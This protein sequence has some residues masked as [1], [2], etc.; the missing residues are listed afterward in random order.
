M[1]EKT[2]TPKSTPTDPKKNK[3]QE[4]SDEQL[5]GV[6]GGLGGDPDRPVI[7]GKQPTP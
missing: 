2:E 6:A 1:N 4:L 3:E 7:A 5:D